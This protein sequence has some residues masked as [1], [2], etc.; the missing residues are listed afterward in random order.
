MKYNKK[1]IIYLYHIFKVTPQC[2]IINLKKLS[3]L[4]FIF[5][6]KQNYVHSGVGST[7]AMFARL[8]DWC[9]SDVF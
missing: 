4:K 5:L 6:L 3:N 2:L 1:Y 8:M 7:T 9:D